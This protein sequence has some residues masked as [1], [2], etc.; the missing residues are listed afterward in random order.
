M[1][2]NA[3]KSIGVGIASSLVVAGVMTATGAV[4]KGRDM[5]HLRKKREEDN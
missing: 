5:L 2:H 1:K 4:N 3:L